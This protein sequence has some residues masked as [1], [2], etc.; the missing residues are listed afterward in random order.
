MKRITNSLLIKKAFIALAAVLLP[1]VVAFIYNYQS[2]KAFL[3]S[4]SLNALTA[5]AEAY[6]GQVYQFMEL[7]RRRAQD[8]SSDGFGHERDR[9]G[10]G[11]LRRTVFPRRQARYH[12]TGA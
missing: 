4:N 9:V 1:V 12:A 11:C 10:Q 2:N 3:K 5:I 7:S 6:E 8:F